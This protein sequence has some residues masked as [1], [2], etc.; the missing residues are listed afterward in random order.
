M[1]LKTDLY[2]AAGPTRKSGKKIRTVGTDTN[3]L[4]KQ[5]PEEEQFEGLAQFL[6]EAFEAGRRRRLGVGSNSNRI[7]SYLIDF[8]QKYK[9]WNKAIATYYVDRAL[10]I[11]TN[12]HGDI[13]AILQ[14]DGK[15]TNVV[16]AEFDRKKTPYEHLMALENLFPNRREVS[17][18][19][20]QKWVLYYL[21]NYKKAVEKYYPDDADRWD[22]QWHSEASRLQTS[23]SKW[24]TNKRLD[25]TI[26]NVQGHLKVVGYAF[27]QLLN[28]WNSMSQD[29]WKRE[30]ETIQ[31]Y[32]AAV[33][34]ANLP[35]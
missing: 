10:A 34:N 6:T 9:H 26:T 17:N 5:F 21:K 27:E 30:S 3:A 35:N 13:N 31:G 33:K 19:H 28:N 1:P 32:I 23:W 12:P 14:L 7:V 16:E 29:A 24:T 2:F 15:P 25:S 8:S 22:L 18:P 20:N 11:H 4:V